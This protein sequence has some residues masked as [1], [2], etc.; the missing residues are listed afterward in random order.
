ML[1]L[2]FVDLLLYWVV[3]GYASDYTLLEFVLRW[4]GVIWVILGLKVVSFDYVMWWYCDVCVDEWL[5]Y[6]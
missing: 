5:F 1:V 2:M 6:V 4:Y 3:L